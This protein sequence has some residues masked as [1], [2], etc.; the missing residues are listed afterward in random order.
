MKD[1]SDLEVA[2]TSA[3]IIADFRKIL[4]NYKIN[5]P[6]PEPPAPKDSAIIDTNYVRKPSLDNLSDKEKPKDVLN[7]IEEIVDANDEKL[8]ASIYRESL[9]MDGD[10]T[11]RSRKDSFELVGKVQRQEF[12]RETLNFDLDH[13]IKERTDWLQNYTTSFDSVLDDI[14]MFVTSDVNTMDCY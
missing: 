6:T 8:L 10:D 12:L 2:K 14:I 5:E 3:N 11:E 1:E 7:V 9:R 4:L 13:Y